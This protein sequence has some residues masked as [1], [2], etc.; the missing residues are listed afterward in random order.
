VPLTGRRATPEP[1]NL[2]ENLLADRALERLFAPLQPATAIL[3]AVSGGPDSMALLHLLARWAAGKE[4]PRLLAATIDH[5]LRV[6]AVEEAALVAGRCA[7]LGIPHQTLPWLGPKPAAGLQEAAREARYTLLVSVARS[8]GASHLVTAHTQDDQAETLLM[9]LA[10][11]SGLAGLGGMRPE[12]ERD[13][14]RHVRPLLDVGKRRLVDLCR[15]EGWPFVEDPS[16]ADPRF[17]R[18]RWRRI[19]PQL[20]LEG[21]SAARLARLAIRARR[22]EEA[23]DRKAREAF[24]RARSDVEGG[25]AIKASVLVDE[26]FE[27]AVRV[28][29]LGLLALRGASHHDRLERVEAATERLREAAG[30]RRRLRLTLAGALITLDAD[31]ELHFA[32][33]PARRRGRYPF[34]S[35]SAAAPPHSLGKGEGHA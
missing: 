32:P 18:A 9:R 23:L 14:I 22:I 31:G 15:Q 5:G 34:V 25:V 13:S 24:E 4:R 11:G 26:P 35:D 27:I 19:M 12:V 8:E 33:E 28:L 6:E 21:L 3:V 20:A 10:S 29:A 7:E 17:A 16:N 2:P 30:Q 1:E